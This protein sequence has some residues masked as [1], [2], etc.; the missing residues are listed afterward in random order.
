MSMYLLGS[1]VLGANLVSR[2]DFRL[3]LATQRVARLLSIIYILNAETAKKVIAK[4]SDI[5]K[6]VITESFCEK[7]CHKLP[8][9]GVILMRVTI[10]MGLCVFQGCRGWR[11]QKPRTFVCAVQPQGT[12][13][14]PVARTTFYIGLE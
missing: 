4:L 2:I 3:V 13:S 8:M 1:W 10:S 12:S 6:F 9:F 5:T 11:R 7:R 14:I